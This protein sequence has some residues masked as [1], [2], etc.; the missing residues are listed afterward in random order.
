MRTCRGDEQGPLG[1]V[2]ALDVDEVLFH[3]GVLG[4]EFVEIDGLGIH[5]DLSGEETDGLG[6]AAYRIDI[7]SLDDGGLGGVGRGHEQTIA[8]LGDGLEGHGEDPLDGPG[9]AGEGQLADDGV[10]A[11]PVES[12]LSN[13]LPG[14]RCGFSPVPSHSRALRISRFCTSLANVEDNSLLGL[15]P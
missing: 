14:G 1:V 10:V 9:F 4:E 2:L 8:A 7:Q 3:V 5:V 15:V 11:G 6:E 13:Y 12:D